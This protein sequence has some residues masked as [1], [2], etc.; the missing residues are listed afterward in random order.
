MQ[1]EGYHYSITRVRMRT[2]NGWTTIVMFCIALSWRL[3]VLTGVRPKEL[4][5]YARPTRNV[6]QWCTNW[7]VSP[8][9]HVWVVC[10]VYGTCLNYPL[11][12]YRR[13]IDWKDRSGH[14]IRMF[15]HLTSIVG[16]RTKYFFKYSSHVLLHFFRLRQDIP[17]RL[18]TASQLE[19]MAH[20]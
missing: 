1:L 15:L 11:G 3:L 2:S 5:E 20:A 7:Q 19:T 4:L 12:Q 8:N 17:V 16:S 18:T 13:K 14:C 9:S 10:R 6:A